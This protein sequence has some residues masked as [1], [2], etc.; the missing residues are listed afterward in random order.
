MFT[1]VYDDI[2]QMTIAKVLDFYDDEIRRLDEASRRQKYEKMSQSPFLFFR[3]SS[4]LFYYDLTRIPL[5]FDTPVETPTWIQGD[6]H[7]ENFGVHGNAKGEIIY[8]VNDFDEGYLGSYLY[9]VIRMA[10]SV[11]LFADEVAY[12]PEPAIKAYI[13][14]YLHDLHEY[15]NGKNPS[16]ICF[17]VKNT[18]GPI[19]KLIKKA[20]K[21]KAD[22]LGERTAVI[23]GHRK[24]LDLPDMKRVEKETYAAIEAIWP[25]YIASVDENDRRDDAF[26]A[27]KDIVHKLDSGTASIGLERYY[28]LINGEGKEEPDVILEMKQAQ[29]AV[30]SLFVSVYREDVE[31]V[32]QGLRV[33]ASQKAM[34]ADE[35]PHLG[36]VTMHQKEYYIRERSP[37]KKKLKA[38]HIKSQDDLENVLALQGRITAKIHARAD[39]DAGIKA[40]V[41]THHADVAIIEAIGQSEQVFLQQIQR[42]SNAYAERTKLDFHV[43]LNWMTNR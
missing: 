6:L 24:F 9:D 40:T 3:G 20:E 22:L 17:T 12:D 29:T 31:A 32:H 39:M 14:N 13:E 11:R 34:Q 42:W 18:K 1:T 5:G 2:R 19:R 30:P 25:N 37:Y 26:Y 36:Y 10:V 35:D 33:V 28:I 43:F 38:K 41:L 16:D 23:D 4:H 8:D 7:F 15:A 21:K 27:I